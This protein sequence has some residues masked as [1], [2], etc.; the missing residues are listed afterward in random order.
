MDLIKISG[1]M[2]STYYWEQ[3]TFRIL[4]NIHA[5]HGEDFIF[6]Q[7]NAPC[8]AAT[9]IKEGFNELNIKN[10]PW[11]SCSPDLNPMENIWSILSSKVYENGQTFSDVKSLE[12]K[13]EK[14]WKNKPYRS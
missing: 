9:Y 6:M 4:P 8:H 3:V 1:R 7:D 12:K 2:N 5:I 14:N 10:L 13:I 11:P